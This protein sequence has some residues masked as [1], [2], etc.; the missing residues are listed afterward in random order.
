MNDAIGNAG[1]FTA[2]NF[3]EAME[4]AYDVI[5]PVPV[6]TGLVTTT[7]VTTGPVTTTPV[8]TTP[9]TTGPLTTTPLTT[10]PVMIGSGEQDRKKMPS[11]FFLLLIFI[12]N[13]FLK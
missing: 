6:T 11:M 1:N 8:R 2:G 3:T 13:K 10:G 9:V 5:C 12:I 7:P 4:A